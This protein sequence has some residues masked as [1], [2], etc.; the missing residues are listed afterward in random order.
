[1]LLPA[2]TTDRGTRKQHSVGKVHGVR[3]PLLAQKGESSNGALH[4]AH[5]PHAFPLPVQRRG[6]RRGKPPF[7]Q[8]AQ[9]KWR[10]GRRKGGRVQPS[11]PRPPK[12]LT[13]LA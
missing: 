2:G 3:Y 10:N 11:P 5:A 4:L 12:L 8:R 13:A 6:L 7:F 1:M 9:K